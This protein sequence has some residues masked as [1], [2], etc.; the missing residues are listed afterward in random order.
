MFRNLMAALLFLAVLLALSM[1]DL[2]AQGDKTDK[3]AQEIARLQGKY[4]DAL[5][6][7]PGVNGHG[8]GLKNK[9]PALVIFVED[10]KGTKNAE[11]FLIK[12]NEKG[13]KK[14]EKATLEGRPVVIEVVGVIRPQSRTGQEPPKDEK[15]V[16]RPLKFAPKDPTATFSLGGQSKL[17]QCADAAAVEKLVGKDAAKGLVDAVD[18]EKE[19]IVLVSW[20]TSGP[21]DGSLKHEVKGAGKER[22]LTFFVQGP[23]GAK[24][25][26]QRARL[27]A[28]FFAVPKSIAVTFEA[29][30][31]R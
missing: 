20:T 15:V 27:G 6:K 28:D 29:K 5:L 11:A 24:A 13:N 4:G 16:V 10:E 8:I 12:E 14:N 26:G 9:R 31:R 18:F 1:S 21:P 30:E 25:R 2:F 7:L 3:E 23:A 19:K 17:T 22:K